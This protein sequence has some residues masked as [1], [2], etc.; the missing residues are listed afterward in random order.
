MPATSE[1]DLDAS[2]CH[3]KETLTMLQLSSAQI[4]S[5]MEDGDISITELSN[6]LGTISTSAQQIRELLNDSPDDAVVY[7]ENIQT[8]VQRGIMACQF[9]D[10]VTQR[11]CHVTDALQHLGDLV[12]S[13]DGFTNPDSWLKLQEEIRSS[14]TMESER[15]MF[16]HIMMGAS[17]EEALEI[18]QHHFSTAADDDSGDEIELF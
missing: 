12:S 8:E 14:F 1:L 5:S 15:I 9:H 2:W 7:A 6:T 3:I 17:V 10:R 18:Y 4:R 13:E 11:L 16:E